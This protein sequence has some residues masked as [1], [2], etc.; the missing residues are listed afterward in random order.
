MTPILLDQGLPRS[1][2]ALLRQ[3]GYDAIHVGEVLEQVGHELNSG[4][5]VTVT[6]ETIL[7]RRLPLWKRQ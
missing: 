3:R 6:L 5:F 7:I 4:C 1:T 2:A